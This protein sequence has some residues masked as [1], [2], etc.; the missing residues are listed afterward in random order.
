MKMQ[1]NDTENDNEHDQLHRTKILLFKI[2]FLVSNAF[3]Y[4]NK[5]RMENNEWFISNFNDNSPF[6]S[7]YIPV[8]LWFDLKISQ[9]YGD[10]SFL[11]VRN[12]INKNSTFKP[13]KTT[14]PNNRVKF[15]SLSN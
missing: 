11:F 1:W 6:S 8:F 15:F 2:I 7:Y 10:Q 3:V 12:K 5:E 14:P 13:V 9:N 4:I